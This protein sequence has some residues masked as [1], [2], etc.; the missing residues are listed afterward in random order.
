M[1]IIIIILFATLNITMAHAQ[2]W[3]HIIGFPYRDDIRGRLIEQYDHGYLMSSNWRKGTGNTHGWLVKTDINGNVLWD[4]QMG[5]LPDQTGIVGV[6]C[7]DMGNIYTFGWLKS[8]NYANEFPFIIKLNTCGEKLWCRMFSL[9]GY[10]CGDFRD[11]II[12]ENGDL[13]CLA[14]MPEDDVSNNNRILLYRV[15]SEGEFLWCKGYAKHEDHPYYGD[16]NGETINQLGHQYI[17]SGTVYSP[18]PDDPNPYHVWQRPMFIGISEDF[19]EQWIL[20]FGIADSTLGKGQTVVAINDTLLMGVGRHRFAE[21]G[22]LDQEA[23][24][25]LFNS[26]GKQLGYHLIKDKQLGPEVL[27]SIIQ[28][29]EK[30]NCDKYLVTAGYLYSEDKEGWGEIIIDTAGYVYDYA[31]REHT[32]SGNNLVRTFDGKYTFS[33]DYKLPGQTYYDIYHYKLNEN[34]EHDTL[35]PGTYTY[36]SLCGHTIESS[37]IDLSGCEVITSMD[38]I[39]TLEQYNEKMQGIRI[40]ASPN[41]SGT[42]EV[43]LE[44]ENTR[45]FTNMELRVT[46]VYGK[47]IHHET[48]YPQQGATRLNTSQWPAGFYLAAIFSNEQ[49]KGKCKIVLK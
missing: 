24:L 37:V 38:E 40:K 7:D 1:K 22:I 8:P 48:V 28:S 17:I 9:D 36:D 23:M 12:L 43:L 45:S 46:D 30:I 41:P 32:R 44:Y 14:Y 39:P 11:V 27:E 33:T 2:K 20:E 18:Y 25:M 29:I 10:T 3:E 21:N 34:L 13:L 5:L 49:I 16:P 42:G 6:R 35:Y 15:S 19:E 31:I 26:E 4:K 47:Q